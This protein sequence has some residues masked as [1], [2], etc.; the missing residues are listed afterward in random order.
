MSDDRVA[1]HE[2]FQKTAQQ[3]DADMMGMYVFAATEILLFGGLFA[4]IYVVRL[5]HPAEVVEASK[6]LHTW[7]GAINTAVLL[8]SGLAVALAVQ[9]SRR[10]AVRQT[11]AYLLGAAALGVGFLGIKAYE[12]GREYAD[13]LL[14]AVSDPQRFSTP[15][16]HLFMD[17]YLVSTGL[18]AVHVTIGILV[19]SFFAWRVGSRRL[20]L[21]HHAV[22]VEVAGVYWHLVDIVWVLLYPALYLVR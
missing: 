8:T 12:Y 10:G 11:A 7:I 17:L 2:P 4:A 6:K 14:P 20:T 21:P 3:H 19:L 5:T 13:G 15:V 18:H 16:E 1:L 22:S 9:A